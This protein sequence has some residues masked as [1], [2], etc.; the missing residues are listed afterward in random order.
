MFD[1]L[2]SVVSIINRLHDILLLVVRKLGL[3][4][5]DKQL[6]FWIA[7]HLGSPNNKH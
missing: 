6:H 1:L 3:H 4:F 7:N 2:K 5:N